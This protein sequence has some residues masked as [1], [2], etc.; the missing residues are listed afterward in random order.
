MDNRGNRGGDRGIHL[1]QGQ[2]G[3]GQG[4][5]PGQGQGGYPGQ[6]GYG[7]APPGQP[8]G[9][10]PGGNRK[11]LIIGAIVAAVVLI[12]AAVAAFL[13]LG[14]DGGV[15]DYL[16]E[17]CP[18]MKDWQTDIAAP[19]DEL[20]GIPPETTIPEAQATLDPLLGEAVAATDDFTSQIEDLEPPDVEGGEEFHNAL[21]EA[22][23]SIK[24]L[25]ETARAE[26]AAV[27]PDDTAAFQ[28]AASNFQTNGQAEIDELEATFDNLDAPE[29]EE[30]G[31]ELEECE[32]IGD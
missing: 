23:S 24:T 27:P 28:L 22:G 14:G 20:E 13:L 6:P 9:G 16:T 2:G 18:A 5:G 29:I 7:G 4:Y 25:F 11:P 15:D 19:F 31:R 26:I 30:A 8:G 3:Y 10:R 12:A 1:A 21:L 17:A 32:G